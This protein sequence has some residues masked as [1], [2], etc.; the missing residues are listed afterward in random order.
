MLNNKG[1]YSLEAA[2][3]VPFLLI[4][5]IMFLSVMISFFYRGYYEMELNSQ[6][7]KRD[8]HNEADFK[9][10]TKKIDFTFINKNQTLKQVNYN[11][12]FIDNLLLE[13]IIS[14]VKEWFDE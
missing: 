9:M 1:Q 11:E 13:Y 14:D 4:I 5:I 6:L 10:N 2:I 8:Y 7:I 12:N 3:I